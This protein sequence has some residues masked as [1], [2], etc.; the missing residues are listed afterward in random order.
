MLAPDVRFEG[1]A[2]RD[3]ERFLALWKPRADAHRE[4]TR[5]RGGVVVIYDGARV[6]KLV[7]TA[8]GRIDPRTLGDVP[9]VSLAELASAHHAS[10]ALAMEVGALDQ[11]MERWS[12]TLEPAD[13]LLEQ[14]LKLA[15]TV[16]ALIQEG[17]IRSHPRRLGGVP[18]PA[19]RMVKKATDA[20]C[21]EGSCIT[22]GIFEDGELHTALIARRAPRGFDI[23]A[24]PEALR[25]E[26]GLLS[27]DFRRDYRHLARAVERTYGP[28]GFGCFA[29]THV[30]REL[31]TDPRAGA[32][33]R[34][35]AVRDVI[36]S[37]MPSAV[38]LALGI[39]GARVMATRA[40]R[41]AVDIDRSGSVRRLL[42][43]I[44]Q[45]VADAAGPTDVA[46][47]LGFDPLGVLRQLLSR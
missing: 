1:W 25:R 28:V 36:V 39:D 4:A 20:L 38:A 27:G 10:W 14:G 13:D 40:T 35:V 15:E 46:S 19:P 17:R 3:W 24:G 30:F 2:S 34:A 9:D 5:P 16:R 43:G 11:L 6:V 33:G 41:W 44:R 47:V 18:I 32:W 31:L 23:V 12:A 26:M 45:I 22:L 37:P 21:E 7:H 29:E 42:G 8:R